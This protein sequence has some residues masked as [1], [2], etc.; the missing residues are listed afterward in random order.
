MVTSCLLAFALPLLAYMAAFDHEHGE[1]DITD[2]TGMFLWSRTMS[3]ANCDVIHPPA[4]LVALC[5]QNQPDH[6]AGPAP[7][8]SVP[9]C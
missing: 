7:A 5:P 9:R 8:W 3:F 1:F 6:P 4:S 2:S